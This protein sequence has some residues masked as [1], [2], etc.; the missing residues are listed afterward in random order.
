MEKLQSLEQY[1]ELLSQ[2]KQVCR[3]GYTNNYLSMDMVKRYIDIQRI[4]Y[5]AEEKALSFITDEEKYYRLY[6]QLSPETD[7]QLKRK[8]KPIMLRMVYKA[9]KKSEVVEKLE[10]S[11]LGQ[12]F[13]LYDK[14]VQIVAQPM[15]M[16][17]EVRAKYERAKAFLERAGISLGYAR[18][19]HIEAIMALRD[20][21]TVL[22]DYHFEYETENEILE[23]VKRGYYRCAF[24]AE[25]AVCAAQQFSVENSTLQGNWLAVQDEYK[26]RYG[27]GTAMAYQ[28][29]L[30]AIEH[31]ISNYYGWVVCDNEK[32]LKY[33][34]SIGY[35]LTDKYA[36]EWLLK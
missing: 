23:N 15:E 18:E 2:Y 35:E 4:Y 13:E 25:G 19:E 20:K 12:G 8:D 31:D 32:S 34:Q 10:K 27:I 6:V 11:L 26:V 3:R 28:S 24:N 5:E 7:F 30:Y 22:K 16:Q 33:H 9:G 17:Q 21:E 14:S 29:F 36:D 1:K